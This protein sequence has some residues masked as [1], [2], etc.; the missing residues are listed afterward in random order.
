MLVVSAKLMRARMATIR[1]ARASISISIIFSG[2]LN[3][4]ARNPSMKA[5]L[6]STM[7]LEFALVEATALFALL[8]TF[9]ILFA[10]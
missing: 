5:E 1:V 9:L 4:V 3:A 10:F 6:F 7:I 2:Y 8:M